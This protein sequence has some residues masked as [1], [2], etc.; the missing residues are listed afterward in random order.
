MSVATEL[1]K[2][3]TNIKNAY[4]EIA[5][6]GGTIPQNKNTDNLAT[7]ITSIPSGGGSIDDYLLTSGNIGN[8][9][10]MFIKMPDLSLSNTSLNGFFYGLNNLVEVGNI[11]AP[12][13]TNIRSLFDGCANIE[14]IG[15][16][17]FGNL[18]TCEYSFEN[19][20]KLETAPYI[21]THLVTNFQQMFYFDRLLKNVPIYN[22]SSATN[23]SNMFYWCDGIT[24]QSIDNILQS[25][26]TATSFTGTKTLTT[27]GFNNSMQ[28]RTR[29]QACPHYQD[30]LDAGWT[31]GY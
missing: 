2:L 25:C 6:K 7:A 18:T 14:T 27:I 19:C 16:L 15:T 22:L 23:L 24:D 20:S 4:D 11:N 5:T 13:C 28:Y 12:N 17:T 8:P 10:L 3:N 26:I 1:T 31:I 21:D 30:F 9:R 29:I